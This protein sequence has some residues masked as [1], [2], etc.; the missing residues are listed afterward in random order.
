MKNLYEALGIEKGASEMEIKRA[1]RKLASKYHPD[2]NKDASAL[3][4]FKEIQQAYEVLSDPK[5]RS[6]YD[7]FGSVG[8]PEGFGSGG[9]EGFSGFGGGQSGFEDIFETFFGGGGGPF[10]ATNARQK[11]RP[12]K[13]EDIQTYVDIS[14]SESVTGVKKEIEVNT[15]E[16]CEKCE[17]KGISKGSS[18]KT[19]ATCHGAGSVT[20]QQR[21]PFGIIQTSAVCSNCNGEGQIPENPCTSCG[22]KGRKQ[23]RKNITVHIPAG[24]FHEALLRISGKGAVG[25]KGAPPGDLLIRIHVAQS[26]EF[27][28]EGDDIH[29]TLH[30]HYLQAILG[31][32]IKIKTVLGEETI[33][34]PAGTPNGKILRLKNKGMPKVNSSSTGDHLLHI[35]VDIPEKLSS[36]EEKTLRKL[37][38]DLKIPVQEEEGFFGKIF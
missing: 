36:T 15:F 21:T 37:S 6:Q 24:V 29:T 23:K 20:R 32:E 38:E 14:F 17:G 31:A 8:G 35:V 18:Y 2:V 16:S 26:R 3:E 28:R 12:Q 13:G 25:E 9:F 4:K 5:K 27:T 34:I 11:N 19:C 30:L 33:R 7:Q 22:G 10:G 1:Y